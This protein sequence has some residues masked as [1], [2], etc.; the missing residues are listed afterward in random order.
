MNRDNESK[1]NH[2]IRNCPHGMLLTSKWLNSQNINYK[3]VW[4]YVRSR[5]LE[6]LSDK[7]YKKAGDNV[8]WAGAVGALQQQLKL[9]IYVGGKTVLQLLGKAHFLTLGG[10]P[11]VELFTLPSI[12]TPKW[13]TKADL[14]KPNFRIHKTM[15]LKTDT[16]KHCGLTNQEVNDIVLQIS[17]PER[18]MLEIF[19][20]IPQYVSF[21]EALQ[22][23]ENLTRLRPQIVQELLEN[24]Q[25]KRNDYFYTQQNA[26][27]IHG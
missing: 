27:N 11:I 22:L 2:F 20:S 4:W 17:A 14:W 10:I 5:W 24:C 3:L 13:L 7:A 9:S 23:M 1:L 25:S 26:V 16:H 12:A 21:E 18:A 15:L 19:Y 8:T 6:R